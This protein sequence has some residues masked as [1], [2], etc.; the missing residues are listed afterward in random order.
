MVIFYVYAQAG[1]EITIL[2]SIYADRKPSH[3]KPLH[4]KETTSQ[5]VLRVYAY[6]TEPKKSQPYERYLFVSAENSARRAG[7]TW[8]TPCSLVSRPTCYS[9]LCK[10][11]VYGSNFNSYVVSTKRRTKTV[12]LE[13][14]RKPNLLIV[15]LSICG[16]FNM[17]GRIDR[18]TDLKSVDIST[19]I[20]SV[21]QK[22]KFVC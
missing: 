12:L 9:G 1:E 15:D 13:C 3:R 16:F 8:C 21:F 5:T 2:R 17:A 22:T 18:S 10:I 11:K 14:P 6:V 20:K 7:R 19:N 4:A